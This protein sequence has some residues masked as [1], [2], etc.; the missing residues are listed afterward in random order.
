M[1]AADGHSWWRKARAAVHG[2]YHWPKQGGSRRG[3]AGAVAATGRSSGG[4]A[5]KPKE[6][7]SGRQTN[8]C[9]PGP[10]AGHAPQQKDQR[11]PQPPPQLRLPKSQAEEPGEHLKGEGWVGG[12]VDGWGASAAGEPGSTE[13]AG[14][15]CSRQSELGRPAGGRHMQSFP[16]SQRGCTAALILAHLNNRGLGWGGRQ[17]PWRA[18]PRR[19]G[20]HRLVIPRQLGANAGCSCGGCSTCDAHPQLAR[21]PGRDMPPLEQPSAAQLLLTLPPGGRPQRCYRPSILKIVAV[22]E[23]GHPPCDNHAHVARCFGQHR[24]F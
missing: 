15:R 1:G 13:W 4:P 10:A 3:R 12:C 2:R 14:R 21:L 23:I 11:R 17:R 9:A 7:H 16:T 19:S 8:G 24:A 6:V 5:G 22:R 18:V 20:Q